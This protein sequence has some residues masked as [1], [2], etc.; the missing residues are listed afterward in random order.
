ISKRD[1]R[2]GCV[3]A[4]L[5]VHLLQGKMLIQKFAGGVIIL[6]REAGAGHA[7]VLGR[8]L[9]QRQCLPN[10]GTAKIADADLEGIG[11]ES[12]GYQRAGSGEWIATGG[13]T[14]AEQRD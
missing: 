13:E 10:G 3:L 6:D 8:L 14:A 9:D 1:S 2:F 4:L 11:R 12:A 7:V 5:E